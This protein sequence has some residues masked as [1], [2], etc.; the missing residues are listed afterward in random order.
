MPFYVYILASGRNGTLYL[1]YTD[2]YSFSPAA[3]RPCISSLSDHLQR[4][5]ALACVEC[6]FGRANASLLS[7]RIRIWPFVPWAT[8]SSSDASMK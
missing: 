7:R 8:A 5:L 1:G 4:S 6:Q 3:L 2:D